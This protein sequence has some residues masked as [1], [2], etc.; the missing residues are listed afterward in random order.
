MNPERWKR[1][2]SIFEGALEHGNPQSYI[3]EVCGDDAALKEEA[4]RLFKHHGAAE[5]YLESP[6]IDTRK[7]LPLALERRTFRPDEVVL[8][9]FRIVAFLGRGGMGEVYEA[10][11]ESIGVHVALKTIRMELTFD[12]G[13]HSRFRKEVQFARQVTH[14]NVCRIYDLF[15]F[16][17]P[18]AEEGEPARSGSFLTMEL[19]NGETLL[20][21]IRREGRIPLN[22]AL[23]IARQMTEA[24]T[25]AH[26]VG[27]VHRDF[28][29]A[30]VLLTSCEGKTHVAVTDFGLASSPSISDSGA[31]AAGASGEAVLA[32]TPAYMAPEQLTGG[33]ISPATDVYALGV[34]LYE[35]VTGV[36]PF[37]EGAMLAEMM[38][39]VREP[40][41]SP[42]LH[43][44]DLD[45]R[46]ERT[47]L[48]CLERAPEDRWQTAAEVFEALTKDEPPKR[49]RRNVLAALAGAA[50]LF[51]SS[52][53]GWASLRNPGAVS[54][55]V[56][57]FDNQSG[58]ASLDYFADE[59]ADQLIS[60]FSTVR[61]MKVLARTSM[62]RFRGKLGEARQAAIGA[63][64]E[65][66]LTGTVRADGPAVMVSAQMIDARSGKG[67]W[68][69]TFARSRAAVPELQHE[70]AE[71][72]ARELHLRITAAETSALGLPRTSDHE[73][74]QLYLRG[75]HLAETR[76]VESL[77][78]SL[79]LY[80]AALGRDPKYAEVYAS[81]AQALNMLTG[82]AGHPPSE[83]LAE[84]DG[85]AHQALAIDPSLAEAHL[86]L[87]A[88]YQRYHWD[89]GLAERHF[90]AAAAL[91]PGLARAHHWYAGF[92]S[93]LGYQDRALQEVEQALALDPLSAPIGNLRGAIFQR[94]GKLPQAIREFQRVHELDPQFAG[95]LP[96][97]AEALEETGQRERALA[98]CDQ[99]LDSSPGNSRLLAVKG[100]TLARMN[101][102]AEAEAMAKELARDWELKRFSP[103]DVALI[104][105]GLGDREQVFRWME[106]AHQQRDP[107]LM[108]LKV[109]RSN[110]FLREDPRFQDFLARMK[111]P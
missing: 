44:P 108:I 68:A 100:Y 37:P 17:M 22:D 82:Q 1:L 41:P 52:W 75:R 10:V 85:A 15:H 98:T 105:K 95:V 50:I 58:D 80:R 91:N 53:F 33:S 49:S 70:L 81:M 101:R 47:I 71:A 87:A 11:D 54:L 18:P 40:A 27:I 46:W 9:R 35:M 74:Y 55:A 73:A 13:L 90:Q 76:A 102:K 78:R 96:L 8:G 66:V 16:E 62:F 43:V 36:R 109:D 26:R 107:A 99:G 21:R 72:A 45:P 60:A 103:M 34:V 28:K 84:A 94:M 111:L 6:L 56:V 97:L 20:R 31:D 51:G 23:E 88:N 4:Y 2:K 30:N 57:P 24:M 38:Q 14:P 39:R 92:L 83:T 67:L 106:T 5:T 61:G 104:Y 64:V 42:R 3:A 93:N 12:D 63:G 110:D 19:L 69:Q 86:A 89:W 25:A 32:G 79:E 77:E 29:S 65:R 48:K 59:L 7:L